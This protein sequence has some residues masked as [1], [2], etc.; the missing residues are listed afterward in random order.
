MTEAGENFLRRL[1]YERPEVE[2]A[3]LLLRAF[4]DEVQQRYREKASDCYEFEDAFYEL[5][6]ELLG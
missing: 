1:G 4:C 5:Q 3:E 6:S 2:R